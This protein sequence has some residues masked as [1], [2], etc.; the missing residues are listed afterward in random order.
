MQ[1]IVTIL[2]KKR[3]F[4][5]VK[6]ERIVPYPQ[7][8]LL[9]HEVRTVFALQKET[10][11]QPNSRKKLMCNV[12]YLLLLSTTFL[13]FSI[14]LFILPCQKLSGLMLKN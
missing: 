13:Y 2:C 7:K 14:H 9:M 5:K 8:H 4:W 11:L 12:I 10:V 6:A 1:K 3:G